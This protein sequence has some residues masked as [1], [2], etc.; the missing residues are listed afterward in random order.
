MSKRKK[1]IDNF[2]RVMDDLQRQ[3][4]VEY[5]ADFRKILLNGFRNSCVTRSSTSYGKLS[6]YLESRLDGLRAHL[7]EYLELYRQ[8]PCQLNNT[9]IEQILVREGVLN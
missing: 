8:T 6:R 3:H 1:F 4:G 9:A 5:S 2:K 7:S